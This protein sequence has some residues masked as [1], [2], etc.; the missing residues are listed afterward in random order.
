VRAVNRFGERFI[1]L[2]LGIDRRV[3]GVFR[4][5]HGL[6]LFYDLVRRA[7]VLSLMYSNDGVLSNHY[8]M[9]APQSDDQFSLLVA[10]STPN[11]V[12]LAFA[13]IALVYLL[14][15]LGL[16]STVARVLALIAITSLNSRNLFVEDGGTSTM[17]ALGVWTLFLPLGDALSLDALRIEA[18]LGNLRQRIARRQRVR[19]PCV[20]L[21]VLALTLQ[22]CVI[23]WLTAAHKTGATWQ[24]GEAVHYV[25]WQRRVA[26]PLGFWLAH[27]EPSWLSPLA[28]Y[29]TLAIEWMLPLF[30]LY[31]FGV[32]PRVVAFAGALAL[33]GGIA[34]VMALGPFSYAM[35]VLVGLRLPWSVFAAAG[36]RLPRAL[37]R[38]IARWRS[39]TVR[40]LAQVPW[41]GARRRRPRPPWLGWHPLREALVLLLMYVAVVDLGSSNRAFPWRLPR[42]RWARAVAYY[43]HF[44]ERWNMFAPDAPTD[45]G[46]GV[47]DAV[48]R[49]GR[50]VDPFTGAEPD[51]DRFEHGVIDE[52][53]IPADYLFQLHFDANRAYRQ[54]LV[55]YL[56]GWHERDGRTEDDRIMGFELW[57]LSVPTP[58]PGSTHVEPPSRELIFEG[59]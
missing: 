16:F 41:T 9:F 7:G 37:L 30:A 11:E 56:R 1:E 52:G 45:D 33:H 40:W 4:I 21:A 18:G 12:R 50:H 29:G 32:W 15:T 3:L 38:R 25:L 44:L 24:H 39:K 43:P 10:F 55:R 20:S 36:Q 46:A 49:S 34:L 27:H 53:S 14:Y 42:P 2:Y 23:Y 13:A 28:T 59:P 48:T 31:P 35:L 22:L 6:L 19:V 54:E 17:I 57:W 58:P 51:F 8:L 26:T 47:V 5:T